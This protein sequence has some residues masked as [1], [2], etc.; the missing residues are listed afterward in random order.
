M[1]EAGARNDPKRYMNKSPID[2]FQSMQKHHI[3]STYKLLGN[4]AF[5]HNLYQ[6]AFLL[7]RKI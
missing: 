5:L 6:S 7:F 1:Y 2:L 4:L 3:R